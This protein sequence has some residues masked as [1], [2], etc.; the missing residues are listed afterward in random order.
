M[1]DKSDLWGEIAFCTAKRWTPHDNLPTAQPA[2][3]M[4]Y[5]PL[6]S[7]EWTNNYRG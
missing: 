6:P 4:P 2:Q 1:N 7:I 3:E 5:M